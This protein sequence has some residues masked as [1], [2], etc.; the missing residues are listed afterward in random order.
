MRSVVACIWLSTWVLGCSSDRDAVDKRLA[1]LG[2]DI[3][4]L[5]SSHDAVLGRL[6][7]LESNPP[8]AEQAP[9][10]PRPGTLERPELRVVT[11]APEAGQASNDATLDSEV[12][13]E[14][15]PDAPGPR[16]VI[17]LRGGKDDT[18]SVRLPSGDKP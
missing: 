16:P 5:R 18:V 7:L 12:T 3:R 9:R 10:T 15:R 2:E 11:L 8:Q 6:D 14:E 4:K 13:P 1:E 17:R